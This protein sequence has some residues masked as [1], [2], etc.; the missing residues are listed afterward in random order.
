MGPNG[1]KLTYRAIGHGTRLQLVEC[2]TAAL[3]SSAFRHRSVGSLAGVVVPFS[4]LVPLVFRRCEA[5]P[6]A[7]EVRV[8]STSA[9]MGVLLVDRPFDVGDLLLRYRCCPYTVEEILLCSLRCGDAIVV[10]VQHYSWNGMVMI[11]GLFDPLGEGKRLSMAGKFKPPSADDFDDTSRA[12]SCRE[13]SVCSAN[14]RGEPDDSADVA[15]WCRDIGVE[16]WCHFA[17]RDMTFLVEYIT[18]PSIRTYNL[19]L[20]Y[21]KEQRNNVG[22]TETNK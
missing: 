17:I 11:V 8:V 6:L 12:G 5:A 2:P 14:R 16:S 19:R 18:I 1:I 13:N 10:T 21:S 9:T 20:F 15:Y 3:L 22:K 7:R 4:A